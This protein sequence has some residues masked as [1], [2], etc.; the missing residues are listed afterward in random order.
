MTLRKQILC[1]LGPASLDPRTIRRLSDLGVDLFRLNLSHTEPGDLE[2]WVALIRAHSDVPICFDTQGAQVRTGTFIDRVV[3]F[4]ADTEVE[5]VAC[6][7]EGRAGV[8]PLH[9]GSVLGQLA[10]GDL[11]GL[12][13][14]SAM[15]Q[16]IATAPVCRARVVCAGS[17]GSNKAV[18]VDRQLTL[19]PL[20]DV[21]YAAV[22]LARTLDIRHVALSFANRRADIDLLRQLVGPGVRIIAKVESRQALENL[23]EILDAADEILIDRG[24]LSRDVPI[25]SVPLIQK[26][27][28]R[29]ANRAGVPVNVATNLL[30]SMVSSQRPT[31]A[32]VNDVINTLLDGGDGL[33]LAA[34]TAIGRHPIGCVSMI[35]ALIGQYEQQV[36]GGTLAALSSTS[37]LVSPLG[38]R[39]VHRQLDAMP[40]GFDA[41]PMLDLDERAALDVR[42]LACGAFSPLDGFLGRD[43]LASVLD[44][45]RLPD[46]T[47]WPLPVILQLPRGMG[48]VR[49]PRGRVRLAHRGEV[50]GVIDVDE[51]FR[52]DLADLAVRWFGTADA[53]HPG[54]AQLLAGG[55][56]FVGG[57]TSLTAAA[58][59]DRQPFELTPAQARVIFEHRQWRR[60]IGFHTRN[61][62][63]RVHEHLQMV[64]LA[65]HHADGI[66]VHPVVGPKKSGDCNGDIILRSYQLLIRHHYP[67]NA[68]VVAGFATY[69]RYAGPREAAFTAICRQ[70]FGCSHFIVGRDHTG[71]GRFYGPDA[72]RKLL[73]SLAPDLGIE[74]IF[75]DEVSFCVQCEGYR[76]TC[77]HG[78]DFIRQVSGTEARAMLRQGTPPPDWFMRDTVSAFIIEELSRGTEVFVP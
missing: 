42:Q 77:E 50:Y 2:K 55:E 66:F 34:E 26:D 38:G 63:H 14:H 60:V 25:E 9:P 36:A 70:N 23:D 43:A 73:E 21:D 10:V 37:S 76:R 71:V 41:L 4:L 33:V 59:L 18:T 61:V 7:A 19:D 56:W 6:P 28:I 69:S 11:I 8:V 24:D 68:A 20:T 52:W 58:A 35:R 72:S 67:P 15:L 39:L 45:H 51:V 57:K 30:E 16:V 74:P 29:R 22:E 31:R 44:T 46:G 1:T 40:D 53:A 17:V 48:D 75:S 64:A 32:E 12:D 62:P 3:E 78:S 27:V 54:V 5:L 13:F 65:G 49:V 47:V